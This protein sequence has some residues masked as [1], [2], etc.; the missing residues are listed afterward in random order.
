MKRK[1]GF[2]LVELLIVIAII[3]ILAGL[4]LPALS[5]A[6]NTA[7]RIKCIGN[8]KQL[9]IALN[10]YAG[11]YNDYLAYQPQGSNIYWFVLLWE[12]H[13]SAWLYNCPSDI[14]KSYKMTSIGGSGSFP[15]RIPGGLPEG[16]SYLANQDLA[17]YPD[18]TYY[19][20]IT[21]FGFP[22]KTMFLSDGSRHFALGMAYAIG[23]RDISIDATDSGSRYN[24]RHRNTINSLFI[25]GH[26]SNFIASNF[27]RS[28]FP[29]EREANIFWRGK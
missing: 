28:S 7:K 27:P 14:I 29:S 2:T 23:T 9:G 3:C 5:T 11:G 10:A 12:M 24:A 18:V 20:K 16:L 19:R 4:L 17:S 26:A 13:R 8:Q 21:Y 1:N 22:S 6:K 25:D 15:V